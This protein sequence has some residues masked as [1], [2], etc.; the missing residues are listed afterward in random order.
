MLGYPIRLRLLLLLTCMLAI[1]AAPC[2]AVDASSSSPPPK[3][4]STAI[5]GINLDFE[6]PALSPQEFILAGSLPGFGWRC[7]G[8]VLLSANK[9]GFTDRSP[10]A[11]QGQQVCVLQGS[12]SIA[13]TL[14]GFE[15]GMQYRVSMMAAQR[16]DQSQLLEIFIDDA[17]IGQFTAL[18]SSYGLLVTK[19][20]TASARAH[21]LRIVG[22]NPL[23]GDNSML[24]DDVRV[25]PAA[26]IPD[27]AGASEV[28][29]SV[30]ELSAPALRKTP[31]Q[32]LVSVHAQDQEC[33]RYE[34]AHPQETLVLY[35]ATQ[36]IACYHS[37]AQLAQ[38][39]IRYQQGY[40]A[41]QTWW[42]SEGA[43]AFAAWRHEGFPA[44]TDR[45]YF[46]LHAI[47]MYMADTID[48]NQPQN[49]D[50]ARY[51]EHICNHGRQLLLQGCSGQGLSPKDMADLRLYAMDYCQIHPMPPSILP[52]Y[53]GWMA[54]DPISDSQAA[55]VGTTA[56]DFSLPTMEEILARPTYSDQNPFDEMNLF[57]PG[58]LTWPLDIMDGYEAAPDGAFAIQ[59]KPYDHSFTNPVTLSSFRG[60]KP[61]LLM[62]EDATD[63]WDWS[64]T[65]AAM[66]EPLYQ[67]VKDR[68][69]M[70]LI[71]TTVGDQIMPGFPGANMS[72]PGQKAM[73]L[74]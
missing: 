13:Q 74:L 46:V 8:G 60:R 64:G 66:L 71:H 39:P 7:L 53:H 38:W 48:L 65:V 29:G 35:G 15:I 44:T 23:R 17:S 20:F 3:A 6:T 42:T 28:D 51:R 11:P 36:A 21:T 43:A 37:Q 33:R 18:S 12:S 19:P 61:I 58:I 52:G 57:R 56:P 45:Y 69:G 25:T 73:P 67:V 5:I 54:A 26:A 2:R 63:T 40:Q 14:E 4:Q 50:L 16:Y 31:A 27:G 24:I 55:G 30:V 68:C 22:V 62:F 32:W 72:I 70:F 49:Q 9:S 47:A 34:E 59:A 1:M 41:Y 10:P